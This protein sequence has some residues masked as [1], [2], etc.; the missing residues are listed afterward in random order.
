[1]QRGALSASLLALALGLQGG[2]DNTHTPMLAA[3]AA[4]LPFAGRSQAPNRFKTM[5]ESC[6][7]RRGAC[8]P[9]TDTGDSYTSHLLARDRL[10][11]ARGRRRQRE[12]VAGAGD[13]P[14]RLVH[15]EHD[16]VRGRRL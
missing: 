8:R 4:R 13:V 7:K 10:T 9:T 1:M 16:K 14:D 15:L 6:F 11:G 12:E 3:K 5:V 2:T